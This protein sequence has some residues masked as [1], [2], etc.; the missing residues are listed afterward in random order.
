MRIIGY[1][2]VVENPTRGCTATTTGVGAGQLLS[3]VETLGEGAKLKNAH[4]GA[5]AGR[6]A[7][8]IYF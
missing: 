1:L 8:K 5:I 7:L 4:C 6:R 3:D 2:I